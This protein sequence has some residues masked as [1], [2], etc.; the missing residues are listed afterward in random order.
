V[1]IFHKHQIVRIIIFI[2][3]QFSPL[4]NQA[5][6]QSGFEFYFFGLNMKS[7]QN[8][9][10]L[11]VAAGAAASVCI[12]ELGHALYLESIGKSYNFSASVSSGFSVQTGE[13]LA[14]AEWRDFGRAGFSLQTLVGTGLTLFEK[15]RHS[16]FTKGWVGINA[17][18]VFSYRGRHNE[19]DGDFA[20][21]ERGGG[22][23]NMELAAF[24]L[25]S[26]H[27]LVRIEN[28]I[29]PLMKKAW[30]VLVPSSNFSNNFSELRDDGQGE[31]ISITG[32]PLTLRF[33]S[34]YE[35]PPY[36][37][38]KE[39]EENGSWRNNPKLANLEY[40]N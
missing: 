35:L 13:N 39:A 1:K 7:F 33:N 29:F 23:R 2:F 8:S 28:D 5:F 4:A 10:W 30:A 14:D 3:I 24:S 15:T 38:Q 17:L 25:L 21:I 36:D 20:L 19:N 27:N 40:S 12:H 31:F 6:A 16:D 34:A 26:I 22:N 11:K 32:S 37:P 18:Q 9:N